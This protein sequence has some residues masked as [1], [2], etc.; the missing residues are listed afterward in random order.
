MT[1]ACILTQ[2]V[3]GH[4][5][6]TQLYKLVPYTQVLKKTTTEDVEYLP[7]GHGR[8][9]YTAHVAFSE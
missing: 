5:Q 7:A 4:N 1:T 8:L 2:V 3:V 6:L 9:D